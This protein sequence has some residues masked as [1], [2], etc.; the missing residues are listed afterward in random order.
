MSSSQ[1]T[2]RPIG[3]PK[4]LH[5]A[6]ALRDE[7]RTGKLPPN[8]KLPSEPELCERFGYDRSTV[9]RGLLVLRQE[10]LISAEH[11][12]GTFVRQ[13]RL[14]RHDMISVIRAEHQN[15][16]TGYTPDHGLFE[17]TTGVAPQDVRVLIAYTT[18]NADEDLAEQFGVVAGEPLL[19]RRY[20]FAVDGEP[21]QITDSYLTYAM[22]DGTALADPANERPGQGTF[23][24]LH[25]I[26]VTVDHVSVDIQSR[27]ATPDESSALEISDGIPIIADRRR[28]YASGKVV[29]VAD[30]I[31]P[32]D[33]I[34][35]GFEVP[36]KPEGR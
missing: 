17:L 8:A 15:V 18:V 33:R 10:G 31:T 13:R 16:R 35:L 3:T 7:I 4:Y 30:T 21:H 2:A 5:V 23:A 9:R 20:T 6:A 25:S 1:T 12:K 22:V 11:G 28:L 32:S 34:M 26:G 24:Q 27:M 36:L 19:R 29:A 14:I